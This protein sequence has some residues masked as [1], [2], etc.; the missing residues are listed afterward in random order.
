MNKRRVFGLSVA[1]LATA[2]V[3][4]ATDGSVLAASG[5]PVNPNP[6]NGVR[7]EAAGVNEGTK[8][9]ARG[10]RMRP[11]DKVADK[12]AGDY[13]KYGG[14]TPGYGKGKAC[15]PPIAP[16]AVAMHMTAAEHPWSCTDVRRLVLPRGIRLN[17][18]GVD[19]LGLDKNGD[20]VACGAGD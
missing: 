18:K 6:R 5:A 16:A 1:G 9:Q 8:V 13:G 10:V 4:V 17:A 19:P 12:V 15:L 14:C 3:L 7:S 20:N 2:G 11:I